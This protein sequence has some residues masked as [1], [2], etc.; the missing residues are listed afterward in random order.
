[1]RRLAGRIKNLAQRHRSLET[2]AGEAAAAGIGLEIG[3]ALLKR[4]APRLA[5]FGAGVASAAVASALTATSHP[6]A[7]IAVPSRLALETPTQQLLVREGRR[8]GPGSGIV[9][10][11]GGSGPFGFDCSGYVQY[12][13]RRAGIQIPR[14]SRSQWT[15]LSG[16]DVRKGHERPGDVV[17]FDGSL[18]GPNAGPP[19]GHE[20][21]YIGHGKFIEYYSSG[22]PARISRLRGYPGY[23]GAKRWWRPLTVQKRHARAIFWFARHFHVKISAARA[24]WV[25][26]KPWRGHGHIPHVRYRHILHWIHAN[27]HARAGNPR[28]LRIRF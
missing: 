17:Y 22:H 19:P 27:H 25:T 1:V 4:A 7:R 14:D 2:K 16:V 12:V 11:W 26:F 10:V 24:R 15:S 23:M 13:Y 9:Y 3:R 6:P 8:Y 28:H 20:G 18:S 21:L 5:L